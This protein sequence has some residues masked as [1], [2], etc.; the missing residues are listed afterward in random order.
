MV[1][2][3]HDCWEKGRILMLLRNYFYIV[4]PALFQWPSFLLPI[5]VDQFQTPLE[6]QFYLIAILAPGCRTVAPRTGNLFP[7]TLDLPPRPCQLPKQRDLLKSHLHQLQK[8][9]LLAGLQHLK[10]VS[11]CKL[12]TYESAKTLW[13]YILARSSG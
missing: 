5:A 1:P 4:I 7:S 12:A 3:D 10:N 2:D 9:L 11:G 8:A 6:R 13:H